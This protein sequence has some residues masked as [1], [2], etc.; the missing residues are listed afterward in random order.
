LENHVYYEGIV[1]GVEQPEG[2]KEP[3]IL[4]HGRVN[5]KEAEFY[6]ILD[7]ASYDEVL[8]LG[9]GQQV[10]GR[11]VVESENPFIVRKI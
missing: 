6:L 1:I 7:P 9:I 11:G 8:R 3:S 4:V 5:D 10:S 2:V